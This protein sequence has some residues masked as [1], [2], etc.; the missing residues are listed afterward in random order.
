MGRSPDQASQKDW[1]F[2]SDDREYGDETPDYSAE[3]DQYFD[4]Y[5]RTAS[6]RG[7]FAIPKMRVTQPA[8]MSDELRS[9]LISTMRKAHAERQLLQ[10]AAHSRTFGDFFRHMKQARNLNWKH[11]SEELKISTAEIAQI[12]KNQLHPVNFPLQLHSAMTVLFDIS[13]EYYLSVMSRLRALEAEQAAARGGLQFARSQETSESEQQAL[14][15]AWCA[16]APAADRDRLDQFKRL[17]CLLQDET[18]Q[19]ESGP[20]AP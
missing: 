13:V 10:R 17:I 16:S 6:D 4:E 12:E 8:G 19:P 9:E 15:E 14:V 3:I 18:Q 1:I 5:L 20:W 2:M 7:D 11:I